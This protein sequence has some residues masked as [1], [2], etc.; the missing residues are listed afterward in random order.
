MVKTTD[1]T[2]YTDYTTQIYFN[3]ELHKLHELIYVQLYG[4]LHGNYMLKQKPQIYQI[5]YNP[6]NPLNPLLKKNNIRVIRGQEKN[7]VKLKCYGED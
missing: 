6:L 3:H 4:Q 7:N 5:F 1:L 2:D